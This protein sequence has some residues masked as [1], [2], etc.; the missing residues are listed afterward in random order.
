MNHVYLQR[1]AIVY[2]LLNDA[3]HPIDMLIDLLFGLTSQ[4]EVVSLIPG[5]GKYIYAF[6]EIL[7]R[8]AA[9]SI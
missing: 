6:N 9:N 5:L 3:G 2:T 7:C 1:I 4:S 8:C